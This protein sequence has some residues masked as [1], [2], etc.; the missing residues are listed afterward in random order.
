MKRRHQV[1]HKPAVVDGPPEFKRAWYGAASVVLALGIS[2]TLATP[3]IAGGDDSRAVS[4][5]ASIDALAGWAVTTEPVYVDPYAP[6]AVF[7]GTGQKLDIDGRPHGMSTQS[8]PTATPSQDVGELNTGTFNA[9]TAGS[10]TQTADTLLAG[11]TG[12]LGVLPAGLQLMHPV[13]SRMITSPY[14]WRLNPT[15]SGNQI[16]IG[17]DYAI[18]CGSPVYASEAGTVT[19]SGWAGHSGMR[20]TIDH[21]NNVQTGYSHNSK[22]LVSVGQQVERGELIARSGT[23]GNS[24]GCHVHFE[25]IV[26]GR[27]HD[28]RNYLPV[29][30]GQRQA[31][32][33]STRLTVSAKSAPKGSATQGTRT[34]APSSTD[35]PDDGQNP[36]VVTPEDDTPV[37]PT[38]KPTAKPTVKP[39]AKPSVKPTAKATPTPT[40]PT[41]KPTTSTP[42]PS[43]STSEP[44]PTTSPTP[45]KTPSSPSPSAP[46]TTSSA[47]HSSSPSAPEPSQS[48]PETVAPTNAT[49]LPTAP[50]SEPAPSSNGEQSPKA[51]EQRDA[52][53]PKD[54]VTPK[55]TVTPVASEP[56]SAKATGEKDTS[57]EATQSAV[58]GKL[59]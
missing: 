7:S 49:A 39:S 36:D 27:W 28:P 53:T 55:A 19:V 16:H 8:T 17:Q 23:T 51:S 3:L 40:P 37:V 30:S 35:S 24:T 14:G 48:A 4:R 45:S 21:G 42:K 18:A 46:Q 12:Q 33:D 22:L 32:V 38:A 25:V 50:S 26:N 57:V 9:G 11:E 2:S 47:P 31:M 20:V 54:A 13:T 59:D 44:A 6:L 56:S 58:P 1:N 41:P 10:S 34:P 43:P 52:T 5:Q 29:I 15:G